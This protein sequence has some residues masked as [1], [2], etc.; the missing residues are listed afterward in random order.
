MTGST[1]QR[2]EE[3]TGL[4]TSVEDVG[5]KDSVGEALVFGVGSVGEEGGHD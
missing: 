2:A 5:N 3:G 4:E 1:V